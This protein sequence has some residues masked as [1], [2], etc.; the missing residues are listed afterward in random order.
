MIAP[1]TEPFL[2]IDRDVHT[3]SVIGYSRPNHGRVG[4]PFVNK[5]I[6]SRNDV[7][8]VQSDVGELNKLD[9]AVQRYTTD[10]RNMA[11]S[12]IVEGSLYY[13]IEPLM[14]TQLLPESESLV[15]GDLGILAREASPKALFMGGGYN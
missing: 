10:E 3:T 5:E 12:R 4:T 15:K 1:L 6:W 2:I 9:T 8:S 7:F 11:S 13:K 14:W